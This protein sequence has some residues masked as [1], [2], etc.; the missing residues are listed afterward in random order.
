MASFAEQSPE[1]FKLFRRLDSV[2]AAARPAVSVIL[3]VT[4]VGLVG[5]VVFTSAATSTLGHLTADVVGG[6]VAASVGESVISEGVSQGT[7]LLQMRLRMMHQRF[8]S[9]RA[10][11]LAKLL[12]DHLLG[13]LRDVPGISGGCERGGS[14]TSERGTAFESGVRVLGTWFLFE[15]NDQ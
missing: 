2:A 5:D 4:G 15:P 11:W 14:R 3:A 1:F 6:T 7:S 8:A 12:K 13:T 9:L 10:A